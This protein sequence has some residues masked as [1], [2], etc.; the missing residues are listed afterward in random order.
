MQAARLLLFLFL[1]SL[2]TLTPVAFAVQVPVQGL[3]A[4]FRHGQVFLTWNEPS[5]NHGGTFNVYLSDRPIKSLTAARCLVRR[6]EAHSARDWWNDPATYFEKDS[7]GAYTPSGFLIREGGEPLDPQDGLFVHTVGP[8]EPRRAF[9]AVTMTVNGSED[10][11]L[12][13]GINSLAQPVDQKCQPIQPIWLGAPGD[14]PVPGSATGLPAVMSLHGRGGREKVSW[15]AFG[16]PETGWR[17]G[18]PFKFHAIITDRHLQLT[19]TDRTWVG[20]TLSESWDSRDHFSPA[21]DTF[22]YGYSDRIFDRD[23]MAIGTAVN[24]TERRNLWLL[25]WA[26]SY[27]RPDST[28]MVLEGGSM[29]GCGGLSWGLRHPELFC[30]VVSDVPLVGYFGPE[31]GGSEK[32]LTAFC[33]PLDRPCNDNPSLRQR[34]DSRTVLSEAAGCGM[35]L[36]FIVISNARQDM[37]IPWQPNPRYYRMLDS[38]RAGCVVAWDN[39]DHATCMSDPDPWFRK[40]HDPLWLASVLPRDRAYLAFSRASQNGDPGDGDPVK[41]DSLGFLNY[42]LEWSDILDQPERFEATV[43]FAGAGQPFP[44]SVDITL[45]R[46]QRFRVTPGARVRL[47][48]R[49]ADG[50]EKMNFIGLADSSGHVT[51]QGFRLE[52][53]DGARLVVLPAD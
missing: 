19:P 22:W 15:L 23:S 41:G 4:E 53:R 21:I 26:R 27:F 50:S 45:R 17:E 51:F 47:I 35:D 36:P 6:V 16:G 46:V 43:S 40:W 12:K 5:G 24:Y 44:L 3:S 11:R 8:G 34:M 37:S 18:L 7:S 38:T 33:G 1:S 2:I 42:G 13:I 14:K 20:R 31:W 32:R 28:R 52:S 30:A 10:T 49:G 29:G 48:E 39:R 9:Y 25:S